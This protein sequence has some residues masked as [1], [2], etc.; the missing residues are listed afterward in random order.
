MNTPER[1]LF[2]LGQALRAQGYHF[3]TPTPDTH[4]RVNARAAQRGEE[5]ARDLREVFGFS[6]PFEQDVLPA[7][8][9]SLL[10]AAGELR[11]DAG[12][13][14]A[15]VRF[16]SLDDLLLVHSAYPTNAADAV[17]FG[18]DT[19]RFCNLLKRWAPRVHKLID[20]GC[21]SGAGGLVL[22]G[23]AD[24][25]VLSD[26]NERAL[27]YARVNAK[28]AGVD[29]TLA[30]SDILRDIRGAPDLIIANPPYM[31]DAAGRSYR[32]GGGAHGEGLALRIVREAITRLSPSGT[33][34]VYTGAACIAGRDAF[35]SEVTPLLNAKGLAF[36]YE[37][38]DPDV[39]GEELTLPGYEQVERIAAVGLRVRCGSQAGEVTPR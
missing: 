27:V 10:E 26:I 2:E 35:L 15:Q 1:A 39:F 3:I 20:I 12:L 19:Y 30:H 28:L 22:R 11:R 8:L 34:I 37:E 38:L 21:G 4:R 14:R 31:L 23:R 32:N 17:F 24:E 36:D 7:P 25:I 16:S 33:L 18:P 9:L 29:V 5:R 13:C 6:R